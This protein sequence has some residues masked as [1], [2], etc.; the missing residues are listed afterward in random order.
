MVRT[1]KK[2]FNI[3]PISKEECASILMKY[4]Y[5]KD[6]SKGFKSGFNYGLFKHD[7]LVGVIIFTGFPVPELSKGM[8]GL[9]RD[10]Q[11]GLYEL[12]RL[13]LHPDI[14]SEEKNLAS[15]FVSRAIKMLK[16]DT[17]VRVILSYA[18][19]LFHTGIVYAACNF[20]YYGLSAP[21]KDF[22]FENEDGSFT[23]HNRGPVKGRKG[24]WRERSRKHRFLLVFD[25]TLQVKWEKEKW[26]KG[27]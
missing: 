5:L 17:N 26:I 10:E 14:Q 6:F 20:G 4:H 8:L 3:H 15:W 2:D 16:C 24:E 27:E 1:M 9:N 7:E 22:F 19:E 11:D 25:E 18:D 12:S 23:K 13:C 21:K